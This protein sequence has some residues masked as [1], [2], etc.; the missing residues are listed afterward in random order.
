MSISRLG[1]PEQCEELHLDSKPTRGTSLESAMGNGHR[2]LNAAILRSHVPP[3]N[4][5]RPRYWVPA[6]VLNPR[7]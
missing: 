4:Y 3:S 1:I 2:L 5:T 6:W 7:L